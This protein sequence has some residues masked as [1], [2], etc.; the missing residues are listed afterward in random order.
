MQLFKTLLSWNIKSAQHHPFTEGKK[1]PAH[2]VG[3]RPWCC[4]PWKWA[5]FRIWLRCKPGPRHKCRLPGTGSGCW[6]WARR[7]GGLSHFL[8]PRPWLL[9]LLLLPPLSLSE[10]SVSQDC[11]RQAFYYSFWSGGKMVVLFTATPSFPGAEALAH[12]SWWRGATRH[13]KR[14]EQRVLCFGGRHA[15]PLRPWLHG[16]HGYFQHLLRAPHVT[17]TTAPRFIVFNYRFHWKKLGLLREMADSRF[18]AGLDKP[19][20][21]WTTRKQQRLLSLLGSHQKDSGV[22]LNKLPMTKDGKFCASI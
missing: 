8:A 3:G 20:T 12:S 18:G 14:R 9:P 5:S 13:R 21:S 15:H 1:L 22:N 6:R 16:T 10:D 2:H 19:A 11:E 4:R 17:A 7:R